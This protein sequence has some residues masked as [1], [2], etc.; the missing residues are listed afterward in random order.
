MSGTRS[1]P[2]FDHEEVEF[3]PADDRPDPVVWIRRLVIVESPQPGAEVIRD[4]SLRRGLNIV[5]TATPETGDG[6]V[7][8][9]VGKTLFTRLIRYCLGESQFARARV[10]E[11]IAQRLPDA[12]V[13]VEVC[14]SG[15]PWVVARPIGAISSQDSWTC[16]AEDWRVA[17]ENPTTAMR[18]SQFMDALYAVTVAGFAETQLPHQGHPI[19]WLDLL[20]WLSRDQFCRYR[21]PLEWRNAATESG[22]GE[23]HPEDASILIRLVMDLL[24]DEERTLIQN[25]K[26]LLAARST[27]AA[28]VKEL[29]QDVSSTRRFLQSRLGL[30]ADLMSDDLFGQHALAQA[31]RKRHRLKE[32]ID[33]LAANSGLIELEQ[34]VTTTRDAVTRLQSGIDFRIADRQT[35]EAE[36]EQHRTASDEEFEA[37]FAQLLRDPCPLPPGECPLK[38]ADSNPGER[39][40]YRESLLQSRATDLQELD[41][42]LAALDEQLKSAKSEHREAAAEHKRL[43][44]E[45]ERQRRRL[46]AQLARFDAA[47]REIKAFLAAVNH[48]SRHSHELAGIDRRLKESR[49]AQRDARDQVAQRQEALNRHFNVVLSRLLG[50]TFRGRIEMSMKG[51]HLVI[52]DQDSAPGEAMATSGTVH[53]LDL[54]CLRA[55]IGGLGSLPR[56]LIHD[57]PREG[58]LEPH[59]YANLFEFAVEV[60]S[61]CPGA[62]PSFQYIVT[63]TTP[64][65]SRIAT[66]DYVRLRLDGR[67]TDGLLLRR[68]F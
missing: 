10:R 41:Q 46:S 9:N 1:K 47:T 5:S 20:A 19:R 54:A 15:R 56:L 2:L 16:Q 13:A 57:S 33:S 11:A 32:R 62:S 65:P 39:N 53:S 51:L 37:S 40:P 35:L 64:P 28:E 50:S 12:Y 34:R 26:E 17:F 31:K 42:T 30:S 61:A 27:K 67:N 18:H 63:T 25:H 38:L 24:D 36:I 14:I 68:R 22:T 52:D 60:E 49:E 29:E 48:L 58:D 55:S 45:V 8:H 3:Q 59:L 43:G 6:P 21:D 66:D 23:L 44:V 4:V 7:G